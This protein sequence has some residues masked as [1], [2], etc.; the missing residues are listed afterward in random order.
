MWMAQQGLSSTRNRDFQ[1]SSADPWLRDHSLLS[2]RVPSHRKGGLQKDVPTYWWSQGGEG[3]DLQYPD[4]VRKGRK[5]VGQRSELQ[6]K[7][8]IVTFVPGQDVEIERPRLAEENPHRWM[9]ERGQKGHPSKLEGGHL[10][11]DLEDVERQTAKRDD[12]LVSKQWKRGVI[13]EKA[14]MTTSPYLEKKFDLMN[15]SPF[16]FNKAWIWDYARMVGQSWIMKGQ[17][18]KAGY[19]TLFGYFNL[20]I[21]STLLADWVGY[22]WYVAT[23]P[24]TA[25]L[26]PFYDWQPRKHLPTSQS[27]PPTPPTTME[28]GAKKWNLL[29]AGRS[30]YS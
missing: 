2:I 12:H 21:F 7:R 8:E 15:C 25:R 29:S 13:A 23:I 27:K 5:H 20:K 3:D 18:R 16:M 24:Q 19:Q 6:R 1:F 22:M 4:E 28:L 17:M 30:G 9:S 10:H 11:L 14:K 26:S